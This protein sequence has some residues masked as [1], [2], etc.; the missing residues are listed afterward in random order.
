[1]IALVLLGFFALTFGLSW[2]STARFVRKVL[3]IFQVDGH[4]NRAA[5]NRL[6]AP[7]L[8]SE[9]CERYRTTPKRVNAHA[10][11]DLTLQYVINLGRHT[12]V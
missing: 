1:M 5:Y 2:S 9:A 10:I 7:R 11:S 4:N 6:V 12:G 8:E 3:R